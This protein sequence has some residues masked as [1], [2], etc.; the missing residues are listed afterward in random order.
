MAEKETEVYLYTE[1]IAEK[2][3]L[4]NERRKSQGHGLSSL[5]KE[6]YMGEFTQTPIKSQKEFR[7]LSQDVENADQIMATSDKIDFEAELS[8]LGEGEESDIVLIEEDYQSIL[9]SSWNKDNVPSRKDFK[10]IKLIGSGAHA[11]VYLTLK[12]NDNKFYAVKVLDKRELNNKKQINGTKVERK[13][14]VSVFKFK[15]KNRRK[16]KAL[17]LWKCTGP[18]KIVPGC[19]WF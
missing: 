19:S 15:L 18:S 16:F 11:K 2:Q 7:T 6:N 3:K 17:S 1:N 9:E 12:Y 8:S 4:I 14:L 13:I 10:F 5:L